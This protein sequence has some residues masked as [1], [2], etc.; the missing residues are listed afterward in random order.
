MEKVQHKW[1]K[2]GKVME[3]AFKLEVKPDDIRYYASRKALTRAMKAFN[4]TDTPKR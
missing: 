4:M 1:T 2:R 3:T